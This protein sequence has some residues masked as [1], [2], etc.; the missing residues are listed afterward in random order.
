MKHKMTPFQKLIA[1]TF[2]AA[3]LSYYFGGEDFMR[4]TPEDEPESSV[5]NSN[6]IWPYFAMIGM[7]LVMT[8][9]F[10]VA[11]YNLCHSYFKRRLKKDL[12]I[13]NDKIK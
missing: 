9:V 8:T 3:L 11:T 7:Y 13:L 2:V 12:K 4:A 5:K 10:I 6:I 1:I